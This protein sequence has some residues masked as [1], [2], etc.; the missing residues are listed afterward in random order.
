MPDRHH[1]KPLCFGGRGAVHVELRL[2][3][4]PPYSD[5]KHAAFCVF[6]YRGRP[7]RVAL[8]LRR[9]GARKEKLQI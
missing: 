9:G 3:P 5:K 6:R 2:K 4:L 7:D 1:V 8:R